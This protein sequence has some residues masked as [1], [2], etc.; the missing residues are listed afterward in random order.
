VGVE[1][2]DDLRALEVVLASDAASRQDVVVIC[3]RKGSA[4]DI[5]DAA[6]DLIPECLV[7]DHVTDVLSEVVFSAEKAGKPVKLLVLSGHDTAMTLLAAAATLRAAD[8]WLGSSRVHTPE[9]QQTE[10]EGSWKTLA[11]DQQRLNISLVSSL[12]DV[13]TRLC[14]VT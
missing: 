6:G 3:V 10:L 5:E 9:Q 12:Q 8:L 13:T 7:D 4:R 11:T 2:S 1:E 14:L